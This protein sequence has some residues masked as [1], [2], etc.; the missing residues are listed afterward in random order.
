MSTVLVVGGTGL[1][2]EPIARQLRAD[3]H[4]VRVLT[5]RPEQTRAR[6]GPDFDVRSGDVEDAAAV[7]AAISGCEAVVISLADDRDPDLERRGVAVVAQAAARVNAG[8]IVYVSGATVDEAN[9]GYAGTRAKLE[10]EAV[11]RGS[12]IS[13]TI[14]RPTFF[15][16]TLARYV[17]GA[18]ASVVGRQP[19][20]WRFLAAADF[21]R[22]TARA[23][24]TPAAANRTLLVVGPAPLTLKDALTRYVAIVQPSIKVG[25]LPLWLAGAFAALAPQ[26]ELAQRLA[27]F[28]YTEKVGEVGDPDP[29]R[30]ML[31]APETTLEAWLRGRGV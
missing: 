9:R 23:L 29:A 14:L 22:M 4:R 12:G 2:G 28:R 10:A 13:F 11:V 18:R 26:G 1:V 21:A 17:Q 5:R 7:D 8:R 15:M 16:E 19:T 25:V 24:A 30:K 3:G 6:F 31:G 20:P 27:F